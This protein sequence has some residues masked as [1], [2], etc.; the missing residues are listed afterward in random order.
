MFKNPEVLDLLKNLGDEDG[1]TPE[2]L[3]SVKSF[4]QRVIYNGEESETYLQTRLRLYKSS[5]KKSSR[6]IPP[7]EDSLIQAI[8]R[9]Q[10][11]MFYWIR[12][13]LPNT[14]RLNL[15][16]Y[17]WVVDGTT[18]SPRCFLGINFLPVL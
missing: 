14:P 3:I 6:G 17:G 7:N 16:E 13:N 2:T 4:V 12:C 11:Q 9:V 18:V 15:E 5:T 1:I 10:L 8:L